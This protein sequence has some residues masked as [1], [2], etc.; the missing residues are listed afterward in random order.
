M[1]KCKVLRYE[2][3]SRT[4]STIIYALTISEIIEWADE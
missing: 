2:I 3:N 1:Q 4:L